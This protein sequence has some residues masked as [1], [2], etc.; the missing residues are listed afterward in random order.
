[1][2]KP[3][4]I[5]GHKNPDT[6]SICAAISYGYL[7]KQLGYT[8]AQA[9]R[10]GDINSE[11]K[12]VLD[13][14]N[15]PIPPLFIDIKPQ[16]KDLD[17]SSCPMIF[18]NTPLKTVWDYMR[19]Y[20]KAMFPVVREDGTLSGIV[21]LSDI[22]YAY[23]ELSDETVLQK[24]QTRF[25]NLLE[26]LDGEI[27]TGTYEEDWIQGNIYTDSTLQEDL[28][29]F[30]GD[31][32]ITGHNK[33]LHKLALESGA[34]CIIVTG[35]ESVEKLEKE[36]EKQGIVLVQTPHTF[37]KTIKL[38][39]QSIPVSAIMKTKDLVCFGVE[40]YIEEIKEIVQDSK[41][42]NFPILD[43]EGKVL[44]II[45]RRQ[46]IDFNRKQVI[47]VDHNEKGQSIKGIEQAHILEV[48]DHHRVAD[49]HTMSPLYFRAEPVGCTCTIIAKMYRENNIKPTKEMAGLMLSAILSDTLLFHSPTCTEEDKKIAYELGKIAELDVMKYGVELITVGSS[50]EGR[51]PEEIIQSDL[52]EFVFG[53][54]KV[55][56]SQINTTDFQAVFNMKQSLQKVME[57]MSEERKYDV[58]ILMISDITLN[59]TELLVIGEAREL[60]QRAFGMKHDEDTL[61]L[62]GVLS[63]KKQVIPKLMGAVD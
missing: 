15:Q 54:Y 7:K 13:Y 52:K 50:L 53:S 35:S 44:G 8:H 42:R 58:M 25:S 30:K 37:F 33:K 20:G 60:L 49:I 14:F 43:E 46:L 16:G 59:G 51:E 32:L 28:A 4:F 31:I 10:I 47:L 45:S 21:S 48:I 41:Y 24:Y 19:K 56:V 23:M 26:V 36:A 34:G 1:M 63:R 18:E 29:L 3:I 5:F 62:P 2:D 39:N 38:M 61:F 12:Y 6:D 17:Y 9:V 40:D 55:A 22:T 57:N 27:R 11:T